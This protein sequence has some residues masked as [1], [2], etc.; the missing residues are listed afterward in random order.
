MIDALG[1]QL[2]V[3]HANAWSG[4]L[5]SH[6]F[7]RASVLPWR[8]D[9]TADESINALARLAAESSSEAALLFHIDLSDTRNT[10]RD[11]PALLHGLR[12]RNI[13]AL[14]AGCCDL[15]RRRLQ[16]RLRELALNTVSIDQHTAEDTPVIIKTDPNH[17]G[18]PELRLSAWERAALGIT[19]EGAWLGSA[20]AYRVLPLRNVPAEVLTHADYAVERYVENASGMFYRA[21]VSGTAVL[22]V[23]AH[24]VHQIKVI[25]GDPRDEN[26]ALHID[27]LAHLSVEAIP[28]KVAQAI[29]ALAMGE[30]LHFGAIDLVEDDRGEPFIIDLNTT[31]WAGKRPIDH[32]IAEF[33]RE[34]FLE[35]AKL[36]QMGVAQHA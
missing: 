4:Y 9:L 22:V 36:R 8:A 34:G 11:R 25:C 16:A 1:T 26:W 21:Y 15:S 5:A 28:A 12:S 31:P 27:E 17:G 24:C 32:E 29:A 35:G 20:R 13:T 2:F 23:K 30:G 19:F 7:P 33:L 10:P 6:L 3:L 18:A 14:N